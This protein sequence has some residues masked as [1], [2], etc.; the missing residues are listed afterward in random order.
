MV[1]EDYRIMRRPDAP[2]RGI[3]ATHDQRATEF[4]MLTSSYCDGSQGCKTGGM[5]TSNYH[6]CSSGI[7]KQPRFKFT[8]FDV[9][10]EDSSTQDVAEM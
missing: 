2:L 3:I 5:R 1:R 8:V 6:N 9:L 7:K 4:L 10:A